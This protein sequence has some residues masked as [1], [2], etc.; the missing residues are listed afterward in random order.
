MDFIYHFLA[1]IV[2]IIIIGTTKSPAHGDGTRRHTAAHGGGA[3][4]R[5]NGTRGGKRKEGT[6]SFHWFYNQKDRGAGVGTLPRWSGL[7]TMG[8]EK[9]ARTL[10]CCAKLFGECW[11]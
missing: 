1:L 2:I 4:R 3:R 6:L 10:Q 8:P 7:L 11:L 9:T 5:T